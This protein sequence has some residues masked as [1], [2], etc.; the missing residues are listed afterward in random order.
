MIL[1]VPGTLS[2]FL[3]S[4]RK[5]FLL[6]FFTRIQKSFLESKLLLTADVSLRERFT[7][8][9]IREGISISYIKLDNVK[10]YRVWP[11]RL[12]F[13]AEVAERRRERCFSLDSFLCE[14]L[15]PLR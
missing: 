12:L 4:N 2:P 3:D 13:T 1:A 8:N 9:T 11:F 5:N 14:P 15:R 7:K 10:L 6:D